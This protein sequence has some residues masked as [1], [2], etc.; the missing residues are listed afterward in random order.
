MKTNV[1]YYSCIYSF[2]LDKMF[3]VRALNFQCVRI[4]IAYYFFDGNR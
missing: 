2:T 4:A 3:D 1:K